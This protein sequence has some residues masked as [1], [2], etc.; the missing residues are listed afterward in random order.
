MTRP[1]MTIAALLAALMLPPPVARAQ[2]ESQAEVPAAEEEAVPE[3]ASARDALRDIVIGAGGVAG[4]Y[5]PVAGAICRMAAAHDHGL[6]CLVESNTDSS[7][8]LERLRD[9]LLDFAVVQSDWLMHASRGSNLFRA[10]GGDETLRAVLSLHAETL[11]LIA[12][13]DSGIATAAD[14]EGKRLNIGAPFTYQRLLTEAMLRALDIDERD[15]AVV[16]ELPANEQVRALCAGDIDAVAMVVA[17]PSPQIAQALQRCDLRLVP[18]AGEAID[19]M[20]AERKEFAAAT[21]PGGLYAAAPDPVA[22]FGLRAVLATTSQV[23][24]RIVEAVAAAVIDGLPEFTQQHPVLFGLNAGDMAKAG[25]ALPLHDGA[26]RYFMA[27]G[28]IAE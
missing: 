27:R 23:E 20:L 26:R 19:D 7:A 15:L 13:A 3:D 10:V 24:D 25:I 12:R 2:E 6:R 17:H 21:I 4:A 18:V 14:L 9:G 16:M 22:S 5:F 8:N 1:W 28:L 11:T